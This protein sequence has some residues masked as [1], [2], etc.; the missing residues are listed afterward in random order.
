MSKCY[1]ITL[2]WLNTPQV[3]THLLNCQKKCTLCA[4]VLK[5]WQQSFE[6]AQ[7]RWQKISHTIGPKKINPAI[8]WA[9]TELQNAPKLPVHTGVSRKHSR[10]RKQKRARYQIVNNWKSFLEPSCWSKVTLALFCG[11]SSSSQ[12]RFVC[13]NSTHLSVKRDAILSSELGL[14]PYRGLVPIPYLASTSPT[15]PPS[16][17]PSAITR[18]HPSP[19]KFL[20]GKK[21]S[22]SKSFKY[23]Q[24]QQ[25]S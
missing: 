13:H 3:L 14:N 22:K 25:N 7:G 18:C 17:V 19:N 15:L 8:V 21:L 24:C 1:Q 23:T 4:A 20:N 5:W 9:C 10:L 11:L 16:T 2:C 6:E 12:T